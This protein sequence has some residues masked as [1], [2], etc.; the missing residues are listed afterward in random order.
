M[1][2]TAVVA[3]LTALLVNCVRH[4]YILNRFIAKQTSLPNFGSPKLTTSKQEIH[5]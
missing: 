4:S 5:Q 2:D 1:M 3:D